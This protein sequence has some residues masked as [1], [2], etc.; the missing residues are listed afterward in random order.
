MTET[1]WMA[2]EDPKRMLHW[3]TCAGPSGSGTADLERWKNRPSDR[4][5]Q[6]LCDAWRSDICGEWRHCMAYIGVSSD[7]KLAPAFSLAINI[8]SEFKPIAAHLLRDIVGNPF[9]PLPELRR[10][11]RAA[12]HMS[13][14]ALESGASEELV[15]QSPW[16]T[17]AVLALARGIYEECRFE[18]M[19]ILADALEEAGCDHE[20]I[21]QH[22]RGQEMRFIRRNLDYA[23]DYEFGPVWGP[24]RGP[25]VRGCWVLDLLLGQE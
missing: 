12:A 16:L 21:L 25:H 22:C 9:Q 8:L 18:D 10:V 17:P 19:P 11:V 23:N 7:D 6:N 2:S 14:R 24:M 1:E 3:L 4:K 20:D 5:L 13:A 15:W